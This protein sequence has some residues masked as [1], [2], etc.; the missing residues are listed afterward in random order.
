MTSSATSDT[1]SNAATT[2]FFSQPTLCV[3]FAESHPPADHTLAE[4][5]HSLD[6]LAEKT[7]FKKS[8]PFSI[9]SLK[10]LGPAARVFFS[11]HEGRVFAHRLYVALLF[12]FCIRGGLGTAS[13]RMFLY[14]LR[15]DCILACSQRT[16]QRKRAQILRELERFEQEEVA[17]LKREMSHRSVVLLLDEQFHEGCT[18]VA[19]DA[20]SGYLFFETPH[21]SRD[22]SAWQ[23]TWQKES[24]G[25][26]SSVQRVCADGASG[27]RSFVHI[28][29]GLSVDLDLFHGMRSL[30]KVVAAPIARKTAQS[31]RNVQRAREQV[32]QV[33]ERQQRELSAIE[34][35]K[36][37][38]GGLAQQRIREEKRVHNALLSA[39]KEERK[40]VT[41][42][43]QFQQCTREFSKAMVP[44]D[45]ASGTEITGDTAERRLF[46]LLAMITIE[47]R[48]L[49]SE[50]KVQAGMKAL[51][52]MIAGVHEHLCWYHKH[53]RSEV[54]S[55]KVSLSVQEMVLTLLVPFAFLLLVH[56]RSERKDVRETVHKTLIELQEKLLQEGGEWRKLKPSIRRQLWNFARK[57]AGLFVRS[58][59]AIEGRNGAD[60]LRHHQLHRIPKALRTALRVVHNFTKA[61]AD[62]RTPAHR[63]FGQKPRDPFLFLLKHVQ[64]PAAPRKPHASSRRFDPAAPLFDFR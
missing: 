32:Q 26:N 19:M 21:T 48:K 47:A 14:F 9:R 10:A 2:L 46:D 22:A 12:V 31:E 16:L 50:A 39:Q 60:A 56:Q 8:C 52:G 42:R 37:L 30:T 61:G 4:N 34:Q 18:L 62:G 27:I 58:S 40:I 25:L 36:S 44:F 13:V 63:L 17:R 35:S 29:F 59:S 55:L 23:Q 41:E 15:L 28:V 49:V 6:S 20:L 45:L 3:S 11:S 38:P 7:A 33:R 43:A 64:L 53:L 5:A 24:K 54:Q 51:E 1:P 57:Q